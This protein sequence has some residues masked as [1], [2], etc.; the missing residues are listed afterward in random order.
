[1]SAQPLAQASRPTY[2]VNALRTAVAKG[3]PDGTTAMGPK[4]KT[5]GGIHPVNALAAVLNKLV[6]DNATG[7]VEDVVAGCV[8]P[9][10][11]QGANVGR[12]AALS[13]GLPIEVPGIQ[14]NRMCGS[15]QQA[16]HFASQAISAGDMDMAIG[17]GTEWMSTVPMG[18]DTD[19]F[20]KEKTK[21]VKEFPYPLI[22]QGVSAELLAEKYG[23]TRA[24][25]DEFAVESHHKAAKAWAEGRFD[26]QIVPLTLADGSVLK[27][28]EGFRPDASLENLAKLKTVFKE[29]GVVTAGNA[30]QISDG[31]AAVLLASE[32]GAKA[33]GLKPRARILSR[34]VV[35]S[36]P[37]VMLDGVIPATQKAL[38]KAGMTMDDIDLFEVNEAFACVVLGW[39]KQMK[40][41]NLDR[42]NVNGGACAL[43]HPLGATGSILMT[44]L[45]NE[46]E[47]SGKRYGLQTMCIGH[48]Q[49]T[50]TI[51]ENM[52][53]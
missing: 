30:S 51:I 41:P 53:A 7:K 10:K 46:L 36:D 31:A 5:G 29:G 44:K 9:L 35:A 43:G 12:L 32:E 11:E 17:A 6:P 39:A 8:T 38:E 52:S 24:E 3:R 26:S 13:A 47:R 45:V 15:G 27:K 19:I 23:V 4:S 25:C 1:M 34:A 18:S 50:A 22:H 33:A 37:V 14:I 20:G 42:V 40:I 49:A 21:F 48:G 28:D 2:I 16:I